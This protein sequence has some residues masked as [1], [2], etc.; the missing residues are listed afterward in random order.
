MDEY[1]DHTSTVNFFWDAPGDD[2][3]VDYYQ[4]KIINGTS[5]TSY[6]TS[7]TTAIISGIAYNN[8][9]TFLLLSFNC[10]GVSSPLIEIIHIGRS[11]STNVHGNQEC[12]II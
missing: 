3:R 12:I 8:N 5:I 7:N 9:V 4:Y 11:N 6:N 1:H 2:S 10:V